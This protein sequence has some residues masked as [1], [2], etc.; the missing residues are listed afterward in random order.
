MQH[1]VTYAARRAMLVGIALVTSVAA[2]VPAAGVALAPAHHV[3][4]AAMHANRPGLPGLGPNV[5]V[6]RPS[7]STAQIQA[8]VDSIADQQVSNQFGTQRYALLFAPGSYGSA[9]D[10][11]TFQ[12]GY[13]T[14]VAG[15]GESPKDVT[16]NGAI[17]VAN[18][19]DTSSGTTSCTALDNFWRSMSNL[20]INVTGQT[21][22][23]AGTEFWAVSQAAPL[24]RVNVTGGNLSLQDFC[25]AGPQFASGGFIAD[26]A[27]SGGTIINGSQQQFIVRNSS[28]DGWT[29][30]VW[31]QVFAGDVGAPAQSFPSPPYTT[32]AT[33]PVSREEP[34]LYLDSF[35]KLKVFVPRAQRDSSGTTWQNGQTPGH[36]LAIRDFFIARPSDSVRAI[37]AALDRGQNLLIT[38]GVYTVNQTIR[39]RRAD[40]IV[41]GMGMATLTPEHG[42]VP[43]SVADVKGVDISGLMFDAGRVN[44]PALLRIGSHRSGQGHRHQQRSDPRDPTA[45]QD[46]FFRIGG[47]HVGKATVSLQVNS[48]ET[49]LDDVWAWRADHGSG[50]GWT[51]NTARNGVVVNGDDVTATGLFV[52]HYQRYDVVWNGERGTTVFFQ[53]EMPYDPPNQA[54]WSHHGVLGFAAYKVADT[55]KTHHA[56][57]LGS[58]IFTNVVPTLHA[59]HAF[60]V[61]VTANVQL[62]D[63]LTVS[64]NKAGTIDH[65]VND[66]GGPVT[67]TDAGPSNVVSFP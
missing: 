63:I 3:R 27:F 18:Q 64:L 46:V 22:C 24:R 54:A 55:V 25:T 44:S 43:M 58:Y 30:G 13:Y 45:I 49:I 23:Q 33:T 32:L 10:P 9:T 2:A 38:P 35:G 60:E 29:N 42:V 31:N 34:Y 19:C 5:I 39:I 37:N 53:N 41:V 26:S 14:E 67:P 7:M 20:T 12:V 6:F 66:T 8:T 1:D 48:D 15:L 50:V 65:V 56:W 36:S 59:S 52:E 47:P 61:P 28:I 57:G 17:D 62:R 4:P 16:I 51:V 40:T 21:G 11:L